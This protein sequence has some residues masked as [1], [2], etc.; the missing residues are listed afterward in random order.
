ML[1]GIT[2]V[3]KNADLMIICKSIMQNQNKA[4]K[5]SRGPKVQKRGKKPFLIHKS[6]KLV[7]YLFRATSEML[8]AV[9]IRHPYLIHPSNLQILEAYSNRHNN[10]LRRL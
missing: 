2:E 7:M 4:Q 9:V 8:S 6:M 3:G 5:N 1:E 10:S